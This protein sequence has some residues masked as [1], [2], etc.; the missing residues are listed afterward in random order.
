MTEWKQLFGS[1]QEELESIAKI[2]LKES[3]SSTGIALGWLHVME[4]ARTAAGLFGAD[5]QASAAAVLRAGLELSVKVKR[6]SRAPDAENVLKVIGSRL[7]GG[8]RAQVRQR[9]ITVVKQE[10]RSGRR[11]PFVSEDDVHVLFDEF[12]NP[13]SHA[14]LCF[15]I[16]GQAQ[17]DR[18]YLA[19]KT[20]GMNDRLHRSAL[21]VV[22]GL[23]SAACKG[24]QRIKETSN[25][26]RERAP[27]P[28]TFEDDNTE[29]LRRRGRQTAELASS[30]AQFL[31]GLVRRRAAT[32]AQD[33]ALD[34]LGAYALLATDY[35]R[36]IGHCADNCQWRS[37]YILARPS[38]D[39]V[40][41]MS[42]IADGIRR[43]MQERIED[44]NRDG[45]C[46]RLL[47]KLEEGALTPAGASQA[48]SVRS[49]LEGV[50]PELNR[51]L[52]YQDGAVVA[53]FRRMVQQKGVTSELKLPCDVQLAGKVDEL[54]RSA[55]SDAAVLLA[56]H[57]SNES[58]VAHARVLIPGQFHHAKDIEATLHSRAG[59]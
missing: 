10:I 46:Q 18:N 31:T 29:P 37:L 39:G 55:L 33:E 41:R 5:L 16:K 12:L 51:Q 23:F 3:L 22:A 26:L 47:E 8:E 56:H 45:E 25:E 52:H 2:R 42:F 4:N 28:A 19:T 35:A 48:R 40:C 36:A 14:D 27:V 20:W 43:G 54:A 24:L 57:A 21:P 9:A 15:F 59:C 11:V 13:I 6:A 30:T 34:W 44:L 58:A 1:I 7:R 38:L 53:E 49:D 32:R 17:P 50:Y